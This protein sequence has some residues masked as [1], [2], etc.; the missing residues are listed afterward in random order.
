MGVPDIY[1]FVN[2]AKAVEKLIF[3]HD[4]LNDKTASTRLYTDN[5]AIYFNQDMNMAQSA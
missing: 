3:I 1:P 2:P 4:L 5:E